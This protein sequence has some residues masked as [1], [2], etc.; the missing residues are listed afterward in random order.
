MMGPSKQF[1]EKLNHELRNRRLSDKDDLDGFSY[2]VDAAF[3]NDGRG[4]PFR[5]LNRSYPANDSCKLV[6]EFEVVDS[7]PWD[8][9][10]TEIIRI[11]KE[12]VAYPHSEFEFT[13]DSSGQT[14]HFFTFDDAFP[15]FVTGQIIFRRS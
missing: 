4:T 14:F 1:V 7:R 10:K 11:W 2:D 15:L 13:E 3:D 12:D 6:A 5:P 9:I 8:E